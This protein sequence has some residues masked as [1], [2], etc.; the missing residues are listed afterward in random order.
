[1]EETPAPGADDRALQAALAMRARLESLRPRLIQLAREIEKPLGDVGDLR[2]AYL[3]LRHLLSACTSASLFEEIVLYVEFQGARR[4]LHV[5]VANRIKAHLRDLQKLAGSDEALALELARGYAGYV[6]RVAKVAQAQR[7]NKPLSR[8]KAVQS[9]AQ[10]QA[11]AQAQAQAHGHG[12]GQTAP[13]APSDRQPQRGQGGRRRRGPP[14]PRP[15]GAR[16]AVQT[17]QEAGSP[18]AEDTAPPAAAPAA[19]AAPAAGDENER[20]T[21]TAPDG[22]ADRSPEPAPDPGPVPPQDPSTRVEEE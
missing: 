20:G 22:G 15:D 7:G 1:V 8:V 11:Q 6:S 4:N 5:P 16:R 18:T 12:P 3:H 13:A 14:G 9:H 2:A 10:S 17:T 19:P 21:R